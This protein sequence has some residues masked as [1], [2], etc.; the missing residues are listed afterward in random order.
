MR[1]TLII[2][3]FIV[4]VAFAGAADVFESDEIPVDDGVVRIT[5]IGHGTL[6]FEFNGIVIHIDPVGAEADYTQMPPA[7]IVLVTHEHRD[8][9]DLRAIARIRTPETVVV[10]NK[11]TDSRIENGMVLA[12]GESTT[13]K[14]ILIEAVPAFNTT[15]G[16]ARFH[17]KERD[18]GYVLTLGGKRFYVAGDTEDTDEMLALQE[19]YVAFL[20]ANQ[21]FTMTPDQVIRAAKSL[22]P[23]ILYPY[24]FGN[25]SVVSIAEGLAA[26]V[27]IDVRIRDL[28]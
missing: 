17:P 1:S 23:A 25:T 14:E 28:E 3:F 15:S 24:H 20:P 21:P 8:H 13:I 27:N 10:H 4:A 11:G 18:N 7:D 6:M 12:N 9:L 22:S 16:R 26:E 5:F 2:L 19:I